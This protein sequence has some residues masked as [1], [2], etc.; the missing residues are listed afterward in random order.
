ML[1]LTVFLSNVVAIFFSVFAL[2]VGLALYKNHKL[3]GITN[4]T[5]KNH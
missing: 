4:A 2:G 5:K 3:R 1:F